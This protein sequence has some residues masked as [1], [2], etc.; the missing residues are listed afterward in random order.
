M[1]GNSPSSPK[2]KCYGVESLFDIKQNLLQKTI[3]LLQ[4][5]GRSEKLRLCVFLQIRNKLLGSRN[6]NGVVVGRPDTC[7][8]QYHVAMV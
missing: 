6:G 8:R 5:W 7:P 3:T 1:F 2:I 4:I